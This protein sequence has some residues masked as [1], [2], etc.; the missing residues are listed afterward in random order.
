MKRFKRPNEFQPKEDRVQIGAR[1]RSESRLV[2]EKAAKENDLTL[3]SLVA[4][5][6]DQYAEWLL[7]ESEKNRP[8]QKR[9]A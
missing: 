9:Q 4:H 3:S 7:D 8:K 5:V 1:V 6:L 2:L